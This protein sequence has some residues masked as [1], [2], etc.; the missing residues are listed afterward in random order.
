MTR[1]FSAFKSDPNPKANRAAQC[2]IYGV[3][4]AKLGLKV[5]AQSIERSLTMNRRGQGPSV[6]K[7]A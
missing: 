4:G 5:H 2:G 6:E 3:G 7:A 1:R